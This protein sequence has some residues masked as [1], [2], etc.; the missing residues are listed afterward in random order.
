MEANGP[1]IQRIALQHLRTTQLFGVDFVPIGRQSSSPTSTSET[2][3][4][5]TVTC[6]AGK[7]AALDELRQRHDASCPHCTSVTTHT[8][9]VFGEGNADADIMFIG[10]APGEEEDLTGR[11]FVGRAGKKLDEIIAAMGLQ[12]EE[13]Y[14]A[15]ILKSRPPSNRTPQPDEIAR[16]APFL[17][18]QIRIVDPQVIVALGGPASKTLLETDT[19]ITRLRGHWHEFQLDGRGIPVM[20][21]FHPAYLLRNYTRETRMQ[22]WTDMK[23]VLERVRLEAGA[24]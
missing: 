2:S 4:S 5:V 1:A 16:C 12:R 20:P 8:Q 17:I 7:V 9:T 13:V 21:T 18:E 19:G 11:P 15:N 3:S 10:E 23:Q 22:I 6:A 24:K 14:I